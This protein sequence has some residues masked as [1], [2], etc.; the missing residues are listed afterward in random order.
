ME[1][2]YEYLTGNQFKNRVENIVTAFTSMKSDLDS[3]KK[4]FIKSWSKREKEIERVLGNTGGLYGDVQG[5]A[6]VNALPR[7]ESL[8]L[9]ENDEENMETDTSADVIRIAK[10]ETQS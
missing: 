1:A 7:V 8:E 6:G 5:I 2:I 9:P 4:Y 10:V 3:E